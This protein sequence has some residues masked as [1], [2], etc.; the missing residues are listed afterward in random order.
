M[1][2]QPFPPDA[3]KPPQSKFPWPL[4]A[5]GIAA[6][7]L[8]ITLWLTP[9]TDKA[10][11]SA[12][13]SATEPTAQ[14]RISEV[15]ISPEQLN[16]LANVNVY[17]Q[18][19]NTGTRTVTQV[20]VS[21]MFHDKDGKSFMAQQEPMQRADVKG[22]NVVDAKDLSEEPLKPGQSAPFRVTYTQVPGNWD[23]KPPEL[24]VMQVTVQK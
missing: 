23:G 2:H 19:T 8:V 22:T 3:T 12:I 7:L 24:N 9:R 5:L 6:A 15:R 11:T 1:E 16:N 20:L 4:I 21:A 18:A 14:V 17:G 10:A 13:N